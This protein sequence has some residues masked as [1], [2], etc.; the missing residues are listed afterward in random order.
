MNNQLTRNWV[1]VGIIWAGALILTYLN[2]QMVQ[3]IKTKQV[4]IEA[5]F[6][7]D[8]FLKKNFKK[9]TQV[10]KQR[11][12]LHKPIDSMQ[13]EMLS[14][15]NR[16]RVL[17]QK[18]GLSEFGL[19]SDQNSILGDRVSLEIQVTGTYRGLIFWLQSLETETPY[20]VVK[21]V[22][23]DQNREGAG[24]RFVVGIDFRFNIVEGE[25]GSG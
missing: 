5:M 9:I 3:Q 10:L 25:T 21:N 2:L 7:D 24:F 4:S 15:E 17:A 22:K 20:L 12:S 8:A 13:I 11:S 14:L 1:A 23:M 16:L 19:S 6:M 18:E